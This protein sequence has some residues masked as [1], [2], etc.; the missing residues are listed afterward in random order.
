[1]D[2]VFRSFII[3]AIIGAGSALIVGL[4]DLFKYLRNSKDEKDKIINQLQNEAELNRSNNSIQY[5]T[6]KRVDWIYRVREVASDYIT[7]VYDVVASIHLETINQEM[8]SEL[9][10]KLSMLKLLLNF[11]GDI[12]S[13]IIAK[14]DAINLDIDNEKYDEAKLKVSLMIIHLQ[15]YLKLEWNRV[16]SEVKLGEYSKEQY[17]KEMLEL[18]SIYPY[19]DELERLE[20]EHSSLKL[21][22]KDV[23]KFVQED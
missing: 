1:L 12:D 7:L 9:N 22:Y 15:I 3:P 13:I 19:K 23:V 5:I 18:Y 17:K 10:K 11:N 16:N 8:L 14:I 21:K 2:D 20:I 6:D 4:L